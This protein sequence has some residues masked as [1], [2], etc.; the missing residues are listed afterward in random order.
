MNDFERRIEATAGGRLQAL[1]IETLQ[2]NVGFLCNQQ[3]LHCHLDASPRR[4]EMMEWPTMEMILQAA[5]QA[6]RPLIDIT[7]GAPELNP[8]LRAFLEALCQDH[9]RVQVR[10]NLTALLEAE[11]GI[12]PAFF[13]AHRI[14]LVA[15]L[16]CYTEEK[17]RGQRGIGVYEKSIEAL[18]RLNGLGYGVDPSLPLNLVYNPE[19]A[20]LPPEQPA[21]EADYRRELD[22]RFGIRFSHLLTLTNMPIGRFR[23]ELRRQNREREYLELL[24]SSFNEQTIDRLM[25]RHQICVAWDGRL[26]D[27]DFNLALRQTVNHGAPDH[28]RNFDIQALS[29]RRIVTG[30]HCFACTA[31]HGSSCE[32]SLL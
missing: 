7:G 20:F 3:C 4:T 5:R 21:L 29:R 24:R 32:G 18:R 28:I 11:G 31:G 2:V 6:G 12:F 13:R 25:C 16:P 30:L 19:G 15:S 26:F 22:E 10:T 8:H 9:H 23:T 14:Q 17:V 1:G 27:C